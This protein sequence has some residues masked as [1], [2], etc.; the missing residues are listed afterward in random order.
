MIR[1][2]TAAA[3][4]AV[5]V[6]LGAV[7][8]GAGAAHGLGKIGAINALPGAF[9]VVLAVELDPLRKPV[10]LAASKALDREVSLAG[11]ISLVPTLWPTL[12]INDVSIGK[13]EGNWQFGAVQATDKTEEDDEGDEPM[14]RLESIENLDLSDIALYFRDE[15]LGKDISFRLAGIQ[16]HAVEGEPFSLSFNGDL[17]GKPYRFD[18]TGAILAMTLPVVRTAT[19]SPP[20]RQ[21]A[22]DRIR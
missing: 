19:N 22:T 14:V 20:D 17:E 21:T 18:F 4:S 15:K 16:G 11:S 2:T 8:S 1:F 13:G 9:M 6:L 3:I 5:F 7:L 12:E 10:G